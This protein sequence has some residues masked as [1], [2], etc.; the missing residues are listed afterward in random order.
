MPGAVGGGAP[1]NPFASAAAST[2]N[3]PSQDPWGQSGGYTNNH[4]PQAS[5]G[6]PP[7]GVPSARALYDFEAENP[8]ELALKEGQVVQ[9]VNQIDENW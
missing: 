1:M 6:A 8:G 4:A 2:G 5:S 3:K 9:L 7:A